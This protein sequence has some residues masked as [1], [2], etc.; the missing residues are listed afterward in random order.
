[1]SDPDA[2]ILGKILLLQST[3]HLMQDNPGMAR[4]VCR[5]LAP[6][7]GLKVTGIFVG[8]HLYQEDEGKWLELKDCRRLMDCFKEGFINKN[9]RENYL[10]EFSKCHQ[11]DCLTI[12]SALDL[13]GFLF[14]QTTCSETFNSYRPYIENTLNLVALIIENNIQKALLHQNQE[15][16][17]QA[18]EAR[19]REL[20]QSEE[21]YRSLFESLRDAILVVDPDKTIISCNPAFSDLFGYSADE[22]QGL[23]TKVLYADERQGAALG[24]RLEKETDKGNFFHTLQYRKK[25]GAC[26]PGETNFF[27]FRDTKGEKVGIIGIIRDITQRRQSE[28][29]LRR[30][31]QRF[32]DLFNSI[33]D[34]IFTQDLE[35]RLTSINPAVKKLFGYTEE[36]LL[37][38]RVTDF[39]DPQYQADFDSEYLAGVWQNGHCKGVSSFFRKDGSR[40]FIEYQSKLVTPENDAPFISG[41][42][43]DVTEQNL[44]AKEKKRLEAQLRQAQKMESIGTLTGGIAHDFNNMLSIILGNT[45][46]AQEKIPEGSPAREYLDEVQTASIRARDVVRQLLAFS[47]KTPEVRTP[48]NLV[49]L[50]KESLKLLRSTIAANITISQ[51]IDEKP[52]VLEADPT[53]I[54]Q[55]LIN[56]CSNAADAM[57]DNG[58]TLKVSLESLDLNKETAGFDPDLSAGRFIKITIRDTGEGIAPENLNRIFDPYFTTKPVDKGTG[59]GLSVAHGIVK[60]HG[61]SL[62]VRSQPGH[63]SVFEIYFPAAVQLPEA[64]QSPPSGEL[65]RAAGR[66]LFIDDDPSLAKLNQQR[67]ER[68]GYTTS[69]HTDPEKALEIFRAAPHQY[70]LVIT[71]MTMPHITG[72]QLCREILKIRADMAIILCTGYNEKIS[73]TSASDLGIARYMEKPISMRE[74]AETVHKVLINASK[75]NPLIGT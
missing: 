4:F 56:L 53:Q 48:I 46:L 69:S 7:P 61:G 62:Q 44:A 66:I 23:K 40:I 72:D 64:E 35:G 59:L 39:L 55:V 42:G 70:D 60:S 25:S 37:G 36:E 21:R 73:R 51:A 68:L 10:A 12:E 38:R 9:Q 30:S 11:M 43:R 33:S 34:L 49:P 17:E 2:R 15:N 3:L 74:L 29:A 14:F 54:H 27:S 47:R 75:K 1:M 58:G 71:D 26:F 67:L 45:E 65:P 57:S 28:D 24:E 50:V 63:G 22:I 31:E 18:I 5:G 32:R 16:L 20:K 41:I 6:V 52:A 8:G 13:Y 19:S